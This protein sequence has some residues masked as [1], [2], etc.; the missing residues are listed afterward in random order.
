MKRVALGEP[1]RQGTE[2]ADPDVNALAERAPV[3]SLAHPSPAHA[4]ARVPAT[5]RIL[6]SATERPVD[7]GQPPGF[8]AV[9]R[10]IASRTLS[11]S[12]EQRRVVNRPVRSGCPE[13]GRPRSSPAAADR[14]IRSS[15]D[16]RGRA[17]RDVGS[18]RRSGR[19]QPSA[20]RA[21]GGSDL[22]CGSRRGRFGR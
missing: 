14:A 19:T 11:L 3:R 7:R 8:G 16:A 18:S 12:G 17:T 6:G 1:T 15:T 22:P 13:S 20:R 21:S 9:S 5:Q 10:R 4:L 2:G